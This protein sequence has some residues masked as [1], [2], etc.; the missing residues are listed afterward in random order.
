MSIFNV[1]KNRNYPDN[2]KKMLA[3][4]DAVYDSLT[5]NVE[6][7]KSLTQL[8]YLNRSVLDDPR[9]GNYRSVGEALSSLGY[10]SWSNLPG[11][12]TEVESIKSIIKEATV[13]TGDSVTE[14]KIKE[15]SEND[16]LSKFK[17]IHLATHGLT[18]PE[19][20]E[21]SSIVLSQFNDSKEGED[22]YLRISEIAELKIKADFVNLSACETGLGKLYAG[23]GVVGLSQA[24]LLAGANGLS[25]S[26]WN[27][28]DISTAVFMT[29]MYQL[30]EQKGMT[31][32]EAINEM[33]RKFIRGKVSIDPE[34]AGR[35]MQIVQDT[36]TDTT[37]MSHPFYWA[38]F[39]YYG[40]N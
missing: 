22:G 29:G 17:V 10:G 33:K 40:R 28:A 37:D 38:P 3:F 26:L 27:V 2:R 23:E 24:F 12:K 25:V 35:G 39:V 32:S 19:F 30:V 36:K 11:T 15:M 21:L 1:I 6:P 34:T 8:A 9:D 14:N 31:Y 18:V 16:E 4:G 7:V 5:Y 13:L 20:P